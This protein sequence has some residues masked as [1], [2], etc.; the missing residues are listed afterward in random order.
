LRGASGGGGR[1]DLPGGEGGG[2][3]VTR[4]CI[5]GLRVRNL[6][7][8]GER[9]RDRR[10]G[11]APRS[12]GWRNARDGPALELTGWLLSGLK[13]L[14]RTNDA[15]R[16]ILPIAGWNESHTRPVEVTG[17]ADPILPTPFRIG[18]AATAALAALG[19]A[20]SDLWEARTGRRQL[21]AV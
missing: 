3:Q 4:H 17:G 6:R 7:G 14:A 9:G 20:V 8:L 1:P 13:G 21:I 11:E 19:L 2:R 15:L 18:E 5:H 12:C 16:G 10:L